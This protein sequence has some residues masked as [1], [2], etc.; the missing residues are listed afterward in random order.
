MPSA[1]PS[2]EFENIGQIQGIQISKPTKTPKGLNYRAIVTGDRVTLLSDSP[3]GVT[4]VMTGPKVVE[5][6]SLGGVIGGAVDELVSAVKGLA[7]LIKSLGCTP[8]TTITQ[9][10]DANGHMTSQTITTTCIPN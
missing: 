2:L 3:D 9:N 8:N 7:G 6:L 1:A 5:R 10:F 4:V